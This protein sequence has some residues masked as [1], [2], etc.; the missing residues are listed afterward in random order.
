[1]TENSELMRRLR[2]WKLQKKEYEQQKFLKEI[3]SEN[4]ALDDNLY[5]IMILKLMQVEKLMKDMGKSSRK[6]EG[7]VDLVL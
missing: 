2:A 6:F 7:R 5:K 4:V 1:M 3:S